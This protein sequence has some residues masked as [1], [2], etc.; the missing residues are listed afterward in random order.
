LSVPDHPRCAP[1]AP[2]LSPASPLSPNGTSHAK[3]ASRTTAFIVDDKGYL[4][5]GKMS[6]KSKSAFNDAVEGGYRWPEKHASSTQ[7]YAGAAPMRCAAR[8]RARAAS[9]TAVLAAR[10]LGSL[11]TRASPLS[12]AR[13][14]FGRGGARNPY[15]PIE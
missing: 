15:P 9:A 14:R 2:R 12:F 8:S 6:P 4:L 13:V 7:K 3:T 11:S 10:S 5:P 1:T